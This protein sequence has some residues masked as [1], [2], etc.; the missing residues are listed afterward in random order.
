[1]AFVQISRFK[2]VARVVQSEIC[3][4][5]DCYS[6]V[7]DPTNDFLEKHNAV[8]LCTYELPIFSVKSTSLNTDY[9]SKINFILSTVNELN[10]SVSKHESSISELDYKFDE[11]YS[12]LSDVSGRT[13]LL[14]NYSQWDFQ[15]FSQF[16][17]KIF[18]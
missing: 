2:V 4:L 15:V 8:Q 3:K 7:S 9:V 6:S 1:M 17:C 5:T 14:D 10:I 11:V 16:Q 13:S 12:Q 18:K